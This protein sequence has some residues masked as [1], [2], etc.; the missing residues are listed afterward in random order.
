MTPPRAAGALLLLFDVAP[1]AIDEH[2]GWHTHEHMPERLALPGFVRGT[3]WTRAAGGPRYCVVYEVERP[4]DLA[5]AAY[6]ERLDHPT[7]WTTKM[8]AQYRGMRRTLCEM[9]AGAGEGI[10]SSCLV[11]TFAAQPGREAELEARLQ[12]EVL[13]ALSDRRGLASWRWLASA[14]PA[15]M[16]REQA[17]RGRDDEVR[18]ALWVT[19]YDAG[20]VAALAASELARPRLAKCGAAA[21]EHAI[22]AL[23]F[24]LPAAA[25][26]ATGVP[27]AEKAPR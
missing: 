23:A 24:A 3:R 25:E 11:V 6:L 9:R 5:S 20:V 16:T 18:S 4:A 12:G 14:L 15:T 27:P 2:D 19:G 10:G 22:F 8:M 1:E 26:P 7:P 13:G 21:V 17:I